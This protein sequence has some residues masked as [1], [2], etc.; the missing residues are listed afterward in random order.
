MKNVVLGTAAWGQTYGVFD[1]NIQL[2]L[3]KIK[4]VLTSALQLGISTIDTADNYGVVCDILAKLDISEFTIIS[5]VDYSASN[6]DK[7]EVQISKAII[8]FSSAKELSILIHNPEVALSTGTELTDLIK[9]LDKQRKRTKIGISIYTPAHLEGMIENGINCD[10]VQLPMCPGDSR[11]DAIF[12]NREPHFRSFFRNTEI[13]VR[14]IFFQGL[15]V[16][17]DLADKVKDRRF[18]EVLNKWWCYVDENNVHPV[19]ACLKTVIAKIPEAFLV[20]GINQLTELKTLAEQSAPLKNIDGFGHKF[21][22]HM[23]D[24]RNWNSS[25]G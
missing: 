16:R 19:A 12:A 3:E 10:I 25:I 13:H 23:L 18:R 9:F 4:V 14:S 1:Q 11:W 20:V 17:R 22:N 6:S 8:N 24:I 15:L 2:S 7:A 21:P 5:K